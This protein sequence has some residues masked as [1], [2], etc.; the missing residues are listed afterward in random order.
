MF[1][2]SRI[3]LAGIVAFATFLGILPRAVFGVLARGLGRFLYLVGFRWKVV[4]S[5][6]ELALGSELSPE[7]LKALARRVYLSIGYTFLEIGRNFS[8]NRESFRNELYLSQEQRA[9]LDEISR[10]GKGAV[11]ISGHIGNWE[12]MATGVAAHGY[13]VVAVVKKQSGAVSQLLIERQRLRTG[14]GVIYSGGTIV[15]MESALKEGKFIGFMVDQNTTGTKGL[16]ANF[17]GVPAAS[18]RGLAGLVK[19]TGT[20]VIPVCAVRQANGT[21]TIDLLDELPYL[22]APELPE[23]SEER[24]LREE[25]LNTQQYQTAVEQLVRRHP[26]QWLWIHRRWKTSRVP[27]NFATAHREQSANHP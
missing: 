3:L 2:L 12:V 24:E 8:L 15:K 23:G 27:L 4:S 19:R 1:I 11:F 5:N 7:E 9:R 18:I 22:T 26:E 21:H 20:A 6:L 10:R 13:P 16:R 17:F 25:W 14:L